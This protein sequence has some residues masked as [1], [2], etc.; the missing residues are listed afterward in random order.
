VKNRKDVILLFGCSAVK[1]MPEYDELRDQFYGK[2]YTEGTADH[3]PVYYIERGESIPAEDPKVGHYIGAFEYGRIKFERIPTMFL[4]RE[5]FLHTLS[6]CRDETINYVKVH[7]EEFDREFF[8][9]VM[10]TNYYALEFEQN[11]FEWMPIEYI[12]EE[13]A[14]CAMLRAI[15]MRYV[16]RRNECDEWFYSVQ[17]RKPEVLTKEMY[18]LGARCFASKHGEKNEFLEITPEEFRTKNY[19]FALCV[20]NGTPVMEDIPKEVLTPEFLMALCAAD[21][22]CAKC[23]TEEALE[24]T[25]MPLPDVE[26]V[27]FWQFIITVNGTA[28]R[29]IP[30]NEERIEFFR[31]RYDKDSFEYEH[32][33]K[34]HYKKYLRKKNNTPPPKNTDTDIAGMLTLALAIGGSGINEAFDAGSKSARRMAGTETRLPIKMYERVPQE[35][36]KQYDREE[37][38]LELYK[39]FGIEVKGEADY[40]YYTVVLPEDLTIVDGDYGW[41]LMRGDEKLLHFR[42]IGPFYDRDVD[43]NDIYVTL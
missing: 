31:S 42:D 25:V 40:F 23:C 5:F 13:M 20:G 4:T 2:G 12:D 34:D 26:G 29:D 22:D 10:A 14:M 8:K 30:L 32:G 17:K 16:D 36:C 43:V 41:Y 11:I 3:S 9:D 24:T 15:D 1:D 6:G 28:I 33:F 35:Y 18:V 7:Q 19:Y 27:K 38:L 39:K 37:Y 21:S